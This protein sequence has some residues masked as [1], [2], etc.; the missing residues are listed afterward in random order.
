MSYAQAMKRWR[1]HSRGAM[2]NYRNEGKMFG[3]AFNPTGISQP[4]AKGSKPKD[5]AKPQKPKAYPLVLMTPEVWQ[6][7]LS[8]DDLYPVNKFY[9]AVIYGYGSERKEWGIKPQPLGKIR[10]GSIVMLWDMGNNGSGSFYKIIKQ[11]PH[12]T[13]LKNLSADGFPEWRI[14]DRS[15]FY[16]SGY[17]SGEYQKYQ[18][19]VI[20]RRFRPIFWDYLMRVWNVPKAWLSPL[21]NPKPKD[22]AKPPTPKEPW[23]MTKEEAAKHYFRT[24]TL[25]TNKHTIET[26]DFFESRDKAREEVR[27]DDEIIAKEEGAEIVKITVTR[28]QPWRWAHQDIVQQALDDGKPMPPEV[29]AEY[30]D[31]AEKA[32]IARREAIKAMADK[33]PWRMTKKRFL[34]FK[35]MKH[36]YVPPTTYH[37]TDYAMPSTQRAFRQFMRQHRIAVKQALAEGKSVPAEV[38]ADYPDLVPKPKDEAKDKTVDSHR[39]QNTVTGAVS[40]ETVDKPSDISKDKKEAIMAEDK[41]KKVA[42]D[43]EVIA[44]VGNIV[45]IKTSYRGGPEKIDV[46]RLFENGDGAWHP[47]K[48]GIRLSA[49]QW[50]AILKALEAAVA[51]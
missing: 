16:R 41:D 35:M 24:V 12:T 38:L 51:A 43:G 32:M 18:G 26:K 11:T 3:A 4:Q 46:R 27:I 29:L 37:F 40:R 39:P 44:L 23:Q 21:R 6:S 17:L 5:E 49:E 48:Q 33:E 30:P 1:S 20:P 14:S 19:V 8:L 7:Q 31:L 34:D 9:L 25:L 42:M 10:V 13:L 45:V 2:K 15:K 36:G 50:A 22:E 47:S 28:I